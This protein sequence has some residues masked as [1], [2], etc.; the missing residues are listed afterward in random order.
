ME[1]SLTI[2]IIGIDE[3]EKFTKNFLDTIYTNTP[4]S[5]ITLVDNGSKEKYPESDKYLLLRSENILSYPAAI[6]FGMASS[7]T[8]NNSD[9]YLISNNDVIL[10]K[11]I[12][13]NFSLL[14]KNAVN[15]FYIHTVEGK[16]YISSW[17]ILLHK[18]LWF[19]VGYFDERFTPMY[20]EDAEYSFRAQ[21]LGYSL[22]NIDR[23]VFG[24]R[25]LAK[26]R[27]AIKE[28]HKGAWERNYNLVRSL[29]NL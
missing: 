5:K 25:H 16:P 11:N 17:A 26:D 7:T 9:W 15:G 1:E 23:E 27:A 19:K 24:I 18:S 3:W 20:L 21:S 4:E 22:N 28:S 12:K 8:M 10:T 6:N 14:N 2:V 29:Y 13:D